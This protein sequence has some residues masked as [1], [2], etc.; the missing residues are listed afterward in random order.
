[1]GWR[2]KDELREEKK[3]AFIAEMQN[4][5]AEQE[6]KYTEIRRQNYWRIRDEVKR[7]LRSSLELLEYEI[8]IG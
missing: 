1:M 7:G 3:Q 6:R 5:Y 2:Y 8:W 4:V